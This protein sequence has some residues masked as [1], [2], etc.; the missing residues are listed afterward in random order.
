MIAFCIDGDQ[1]SPDFLHEVHKAFPQA[2]LH[3]RAYDRRSVVTLGDAPVRQVV[4]ELMG[5]AVTMARS[6]LEGLEVSLED[7]ERAEDTYRSVDRERL[8]L[9]IEAGDVRVA[10]EMV[11]TRRPDS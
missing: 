9:Q 7:I 5:S 6:A 4:R 8:A 2:L 3:V 1:L 11:I 10:R